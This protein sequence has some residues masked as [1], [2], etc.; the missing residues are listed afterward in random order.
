MGS[1]GGG[2]GLEDFLK[3]KNPGPNFVQKK[4]LGQ[5]K[6]YCTYMF[7]IIYNISRPGNIVPALPISIKWS[8]PNTGTALN[9][10][11]AKGGRVGKWAPAHWGHE[12]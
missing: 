12:K 7:C 11:S 5:G 3:K 6:F 8:L 1:G 9:D 4:Y 10:S 2:G